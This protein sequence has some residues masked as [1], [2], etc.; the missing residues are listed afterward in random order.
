MHKWDAQFRLSAMNLPAMLLLVEINCPTYNRKNTFTIIGGAT[1]LSSKRQML[2]LIC[3]RQQ[4]SCIAFANIY[5]HDVKFFNTAF[6]AFVRND[7]FILR[8]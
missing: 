6:I 1:V 3:N 8:W 7:S 2:S 4:Y 5:G